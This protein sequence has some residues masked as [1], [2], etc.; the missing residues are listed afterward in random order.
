MV[1]G[2][3]QSSLFI[4]GSLVVPERVERLSFLNW[5]A[6]VCLPELNQYIHGSVSGFS[7]VFYCSACLNRVYP[8]NNVVLGSESEKFPN[9]KLL[10][11]PYFTS[12]HE[13]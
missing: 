3:G 9:S 5:I 11:Y 6:F 2:I 10:D 8:K 13:V 12:A 1:Q 4:Y 7:I